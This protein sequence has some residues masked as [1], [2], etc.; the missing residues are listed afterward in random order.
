MNEVKNEKK[1]LIPVSCLLQF[2]VE[3]PLP[4]ED[5]YEYEMRIEEDLD[6]QMSGHDLLSEVADKVASMGWTLE[7]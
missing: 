4:G 3:P 7:E 6:D 2:E 5:R 1:K